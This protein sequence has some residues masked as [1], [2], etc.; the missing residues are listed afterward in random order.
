MN[1]HSDGYWGAEEE[2]R[3]SLVRA[4]E[5]REAMRPRIPAGKGISPFWQDRAAK[6][7]GQR[8]SDAKILAH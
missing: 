8:P 5:I 2:A 3:K 6:E 7:R 1:D 4:R